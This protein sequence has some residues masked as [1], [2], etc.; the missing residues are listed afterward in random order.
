MQSKEEEMAEEHLTDR[1]QKEW[2]DKQR[3]WKLKRKAEQ[4]SLF[5]LDCMMSEGYKER[6]PEIMRFEQQYYRL[7]KIREGDFSEVEA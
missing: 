1:E 7:K 6:S 4:D 3:L 5:M 2:E